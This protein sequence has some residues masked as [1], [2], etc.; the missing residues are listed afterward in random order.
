[1]AHAEDFSTVDAEFTL[2]S[3]SGRYRV[4]LPRPEKDAI[5]RYRS[6]LAD[7]LQDRFQER[8]VGAKK[9]AR[10]GA[11]QRLLAISEKRLLSVG[12]GLAENGAPELALG[13]QDRLVE[14]DSAVRFHWQSALRRKSAGGSVTKNAGKM[15]PLQGMTA[16]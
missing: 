1:L 2:V 14:P 3:L 11:F 16:D 8:I 15:P 7:K 12:V 13:R 4:L 5:A 10:A 6:E 9:T